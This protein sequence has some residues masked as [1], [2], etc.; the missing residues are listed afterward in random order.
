MFG[1]PLWEKALDVGPEV[2]GTRKPWKEE[3]DVLFGRTAY[4][5]F[6]PSLPIA[7]PGPC[8]GRT[9]FSACCHSFFPQGQ[10][11]PSKQ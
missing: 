6:F 1:E 11:Q 3:E 4:L 8:S 10:S 2:K 9:A 5:R 7:F